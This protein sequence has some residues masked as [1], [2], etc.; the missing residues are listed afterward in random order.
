MC[1]QFQSKANIQAYVA[2][3]FVAKFQCLLFF[4]FLGSL[5]SVR[6]WASEQ[7]RERAER[8]LQG[9]PQQ[10]ASEPET[11][12]SSSKIVANANANA[13]AN[14][15][16]LPLLRS[17]FGLLGEEGLGGLLSPAMTSSGLHRL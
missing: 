6:A 13:N 17:N 10:L 5:A 12:A 2:G 11:M 3:A 9:Q 14:A 4:L 1:L 15:V 7:I 16:E 8:V